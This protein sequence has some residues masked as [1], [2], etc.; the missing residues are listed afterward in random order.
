V[1]AEPPPTGPIDD[2][3]ILR[4]TER[5]LELRR[6]TFRNL[7]DTAVELGEILQEGR[8][9]LE[10][11][12]LR[13]LRERLGVEPRSAA[14]YIAL[15]GL[16]RE[17]PRVIHRW[18]ELGAAKLYQI[19]RLPAPGRRAVLRTPG[20]GDMTDLRLSQIVRPYRVR[21]RTV[22]GNMRAHGLRMKVQAMIQDLARTRLA[23][24]DDP[25]IRSGLWKD[26]MELGSRAR[27]LAS[28]L[29]P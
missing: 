4:L 21:R 22:T 3:R 8:K 25:A 10:G 29:S 23:Q 15:A 9:I 2:A 13:W 27:A 17:S 19:A 14:N 16:A 26:L 11:Q 18:K 12:Y 20:L 1:R 7:V 24:I 5:F 28:A 6:Q